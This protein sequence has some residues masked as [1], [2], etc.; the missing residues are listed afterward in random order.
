MP[1]PLLMPVTLVA[2]AVF[3]LMLVTLAVYVIRGRFKHRTVHGDQGN[4][5]MLI[6]MRTHANFI[7]Y[8]PFAL[9]LM[10]LLES[11]GANQ[12]TLA[13]GAAAFFVFRIL[14]VFGMRQKYPARLR[15][16]GAAGTFLTL[17]FASIW[18]LVI[19]TGSLVA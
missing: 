18:A 19:A 14:H 16:I 2:A 5:D 7:E 6:R 9:I 4:E 15:R 8:V 3:G 13:L 12:F 17:I 1:S 10:A 11:S